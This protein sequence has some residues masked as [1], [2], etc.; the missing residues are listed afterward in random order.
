LGGVMTPLIERNTTIPVRKSEI[1]TTAEDGQTA[2]TIHV[3]QGERPMA[4]DNNS[5]G[6]FNLVGIPPAPRGMPQIEVTFDIDANGILNVSAK[7]KAT[8][9]EQQ[10]T[11]TATTNLSKE[12]VER[13]VQEAKRHEA[14]DRRR[15]ELVEARNTADALIYQM[16][17]TLRDLGDKVS[18]SDRGRI[19]NII[20]DLKRAK[21]GEDTARIRRLIEQ[22]QQ[23]SYAIGQQMYAQQQAAG[24]PQAGST[25]PGVGPT[26]GGE[27]E[28]VEGEFHEV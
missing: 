15:K 6:M 4:A 10:I 21:E 7:D 25:G 8:G 14:E 13:L 20:E 2:V 1:F 16:E 11:I 19:E 23:A 27:E 24:G 26:P 28:V 17:K 3:L 18:A 5:L 22:L 9:K 12:E